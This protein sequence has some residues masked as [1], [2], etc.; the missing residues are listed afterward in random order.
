MVSRRP[1]VLLLALALL[2]GT[3]SCLDNEGA[4]DKVQVKGTVVQPDGGVGCS[5]WC[6]HSEDGKLYEITNL[7]NEFRL[8]GLPVTARLQLR[9]DMVSTCMV[10]PIAEIIAIEKGAQ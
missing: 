6:I 4:S 1:A 7:P 10:G 3:L 2:L 5:N 8:P 9:P